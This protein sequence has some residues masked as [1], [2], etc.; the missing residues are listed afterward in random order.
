M[1]GRITVTVRRWPDRKNLMLV[2]RD[3]TTGKVVGRSAHTANQRQAHRAATELEDRLN[4]ANQP[5]D[6]GMPW[7]EFLDL[8]ISGHCAGLK[9]SSAHKQI[10]VL[11]VFTRI[12]QPQNLR[13][14]TTPA[15]TQYAGYLRS[16]GRAEA[17]IAGHLTALRVALRW[18]V[19]QRYLAAAPQMP[20]V[21]RSRTGRT[22]KG[23][24]LTL[25]EVVRLLRHAPD[26]DWRHLL[27][28]LWLSGLR[29]GEAVHLTWDDPRELC[30]DWSGRF[31]MLRIPAELE[32]GHR[33]RH[34]ALTP[35]FARLLDRTP[36]SERTGWVFLRSDPRPST[37]VVMRRIMDIGASAGVVVNPRTGKHAS[38]H[39]LRRS[40]GQR[41][42]GRVLPQ[43]LRELMR[44]TSLST[45]MS[46]YVSV[47]AAAT[48][49][50]L[51]KQA[52][53]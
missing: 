20:R 9:D 42:A 40:F 51:W 25:P 33:D 12:I 17:T 49:E 30:L 16:Q 19:S 38:A 23:R 39:D 2:Y 26:D 47:N 28:G 1:T 36:A 14:V 29:L 50:T 34:M 31:P 5:L 8:F 48:A 35:D 15:L 6:G 52:R 10:V 45:T 53:K 41:W 44:H 37:D 3:P 27:L 32:K 11:E 4:N 18:A 7:E 13:A 24:A 22:A 43:T 46:F 21:A